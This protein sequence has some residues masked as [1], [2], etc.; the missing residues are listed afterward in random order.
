M[1]NKNYLINILQ[2]IEERF[3]INMKRYIR[4][5]IL[6]YVEKPP[7]YLGDEINSV[8]KNWDEVKVRK[9]FCFPDIYELGMSHTGM[10]IL[11]G[12]V[13]DNKDYLMERCFTPWVDME[14]MLRKNNLPLFSLE[15]YTP[16]KDFD[17]VGFT[18]QYELSYSNILN[19]LELGGI[20]VERQERNENSPIVVAGGPCASNPEPLASFIDCFFIGDGEDLILKFL[21]L[22]KQQKIK[23]WKKEQFLEKVKLLPGV[24]VPSYYDFSYDEEGMIKN[25]KVHS[26]AP[27][28]VR[29]QAITN[30]DQAYYPL[31]PLIPHVEA[32]HD[33]AVLE[34]A[35]GCSRGCRFCQAGILYRPV[36][37]KKPDTLFYQGIKNRDNTGYDEI[38]LSSLSAADYSCIAG[39]TDKFLQESNDEALGLSLPSLRTDTFSVK[40]AEKIQKVRKTGLTFAPEA[41]S[42]RLRDVINKK[43]KEEDLENTI[44]AA[45][46]MGWYQVKLYFMIGLPTETM[47]DIKGIAD[48]V[49][50]VLSLSKKHKNTAKNI[51]I[52]VSVSS[53][54]PKSHTPFQWESQD[55]M[56]T[57]EKKQMFLKSLL[58]SK[59]IT[60]NYHEA[61]MSYLEAVFSKGDRRLGEVLKLAWKK[62]AKLDGWSEHFKFDK[63]VEAFL[64]CRIRP[65]FY[66]NRKNYFDEI[67]P[68]EIIDTGVTKKF[69][70]KEYE[71]ALREEWT[72][73][74]RNAGC[75]NCGICSRFNVNM[76]LVGRSGYI[77]ISE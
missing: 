77:C 1:R 9:V 65:E 26:N 24:Y 67:F 6:P 42:Q 45:F 64:E 2:F 3:V 19:M 75:L 69:L 52:I 58:R 56:E 76:E 59:Q 17:V 32:V 25:I 40:L 44:R 62:G 5:K 7:R 31:Q 47:E 66:A 36:R 72:F 55:T 39:L 60:L 33:R 57:L 34:L 10:K 51:K 54:V 4:N 50:K 27:Q 28:R 16:L 74:C 18:L 29:K 63:W 53:F 68:W 43:V 48:L 15:S 49:N 70:K 71:K 23:G 13:N 73:D 14:E 41:G 8:H 46:S 38:S 22:V 11:Y 21:S 20:A 12:L 35:R 61:K 30:F 37:E